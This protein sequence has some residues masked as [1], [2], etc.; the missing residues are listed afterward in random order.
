MASSLTMTMKP[1]NTA[2]SKYTIKNV[3]PPDFP[4]LY[5]KPQMFPR[6]TAEPMAASRNPTLLAQ[7]PL[8]FFTKIPLSHS[9]F[10]YPSFKSCM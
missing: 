9:F 8:S 5:G 7:E 4:I 10:E 2:S 3:K 1:T 6:P